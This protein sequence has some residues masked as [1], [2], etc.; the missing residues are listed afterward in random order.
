MKVRAV[1]AP[2]R[3]LLPL[4]HLLRASAMS[5][6]SEQCRTTRSVTQASSES[7]SDRALQL[8]YNGYVNGQ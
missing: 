6:G 8:H 5:R 4:V 2:G 7:R 3:K 1:I